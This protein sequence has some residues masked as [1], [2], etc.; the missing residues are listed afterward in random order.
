[1]S[2]LVQQS[3]QKEVNR[4]EELIAQAWKAHSKKEEDN[5]EELFRKAY[6]LDP[7]SVEAVYGLAMV[8]KA[9]ERL[10]EA[11]NLFQQVIQILDEKPARDPNRASMLK[12]LAM[13]HLNR[14]QTGDWNLEKE[15]WQR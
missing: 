15:I 13:A 2:N 6:T 12:R 1:M 4:I 10:K 14:I 11:S 9:Q 7:K 3:E 5:A 8:L